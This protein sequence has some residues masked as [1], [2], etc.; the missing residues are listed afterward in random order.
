MTPLVLSLSNLTVKFLSPRKTIPR[1]CRITKTMNTITLLCFVYEESY[2]CHVLDEFT[3]QFLV[4]FVM[5]NIFTYIIIIVMH[6]FLYLYNT[7]NQVLQLITNYKQNCVGKIMRN[8]FININ[9]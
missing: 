6:S 4:N 7:L 3:T 5:K 2:E 1:N 9:E 8:D